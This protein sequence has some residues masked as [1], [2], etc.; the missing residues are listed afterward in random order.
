LGSLLG[1]YYL[2]VSSK[3]GYRPDPNKSYWATNIAGPWTGSTDIAPPSVNTY[4]SQNT[5]ELVIKGTSTT[6]YVFM[7]D[8]WDSKGT[9]ASN[10]EWLPISVA[11]SSHVLTLQNH[12]MWTVNPS[13]GVVTSSG[14]ANTTHFAADAIVGGSAV[15]N[16]SKRSVHS[17]TPSGNVTFSNVQG[18]GG[19]QWV[20]FQYTTSNATA[21]EAHVSINGES[22]V[23]LS[24]L[25]SR[26]GHF[27]TIPV[28]LVL[29]KGDN[30]LT[31]GVTSKDG[32]DFEAH[33][34]SIQVFDAY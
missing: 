18:I 12:A 26:A 8:A 5:A 11:S 28:A 29:D 27:S 13:T 31:F 30:A 33:L 22:P 1:V 6:T 19:R 10:Y 15:V 23:N 24:E 4:N 17:I 16:R 14:F 9:D 25:N 2:I 20:S 7:G 32:Y 3:T 34:E 21:G